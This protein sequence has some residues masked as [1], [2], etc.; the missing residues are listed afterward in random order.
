MPIRIKAS[1]LTPGAHG[2]IQPPVITTV[3]PSP[4]T[5]VGTACPGCTVELFGSRTNDGQ[6]QFYLGNATADGSGA[7]S[8]AR[9][10]MPYPYLTATATDSTKGTSEFSA[11]LT[12][13]VVLLTH[14]PVI[15]R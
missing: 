5:V 14:L 4:L 2:G 15:V 6:G 8:L 11:V 10:T 12:T 7:F 13:T 1:Y 3:N 9:T